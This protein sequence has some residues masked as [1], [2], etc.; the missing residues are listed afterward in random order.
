VTGLLARTS[1]LKTKVGER[2]TNK[3]HEFAY[4]FSVKADKIL[5][6]IEEEQDSLEDKVEGGEVHDLVAELLDR[7]VAKKNRNDQEIEDDVSGLMRLTQELKDSF[8]ADPRFQM[9]QWSLVAAIVFILWV[10]CRV[11]AANQPTY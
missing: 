11:K 10:F 1:E 7:S 5:K 3:G 2:E 6:E 9:L 4:E 8:H